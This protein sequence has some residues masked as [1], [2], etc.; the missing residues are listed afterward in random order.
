MNTV[1]IYRDGEAVPVIRAVARPYPWRRQTTVALL[2]SNALM[3]LDAHGETSFDKDTLLQRGID[4]ALAT[5]L[6]Q[7]PQFTAGRHPVTLT[8]NGQRHGRV[9]VTF[10][11]E[12]ALCFDR[13]LLDAANLT[14]P[15]L[16]LD[17]VSATI[18]LAA[19]RRPSSNRTPR[20]SPCR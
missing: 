4:P 9:D 3:M 1:S 8:V 10:N 7:A 5:L 20:T 14:V 2:L 6:M 16:T 19:R 18:F 15:A 13:A 12:G 17:D 11:R